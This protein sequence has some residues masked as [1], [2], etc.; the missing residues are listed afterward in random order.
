MT[1]LNVRLNFLTCDVTNYKTKHRSLTKCGKT[2][3]KMYLQPLPWKSF[4]V[5]VLPSSHSHSVD[6]I[7]HKIR[8]VRSGTKYMCYISSRMH[9]VV[10]TT[11]YWS[12][13]PISSH[14]IFGF[15]IPKLMEHFIFQNVQTNL[16]HSLTWSKHFDSMIKISQCSIFL[17]NKYTNHSD[18][19]SNN[20]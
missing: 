19:S 17:R 14:S 4:N 18:S 15:S 2:K 9:V 8:K 7:S 20:E 16:L 5:L 6:G 12:L 3:N 10:I 11:H 1:E 13:P